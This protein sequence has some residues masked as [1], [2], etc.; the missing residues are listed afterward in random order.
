MNT[1]YG[2]R[3]PGQPGKKYSIPRYHPWNRRLTPDEIQERQKQGAEFN[4]E[5]Y[6]RRRAKL[7][8]SDEAA[9]NKSPESRHEWTEDADRNQVCKHCGIKA[10]DLDG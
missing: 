1:R 8:A 9:D 4:R 3:N 10:R 5:W 2:K 7:D 6:A